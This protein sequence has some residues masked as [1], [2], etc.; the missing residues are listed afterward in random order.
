MYLSSMS[1]NMLVSALLNPSTASANG[2][3]KATSTEGLKD[4]AMNT[5]L[6]FYDDAMQE[7]MHVCYFW[8]SMCIVVK[9]KVYLV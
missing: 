8:S 5:E 7:P 6:S 4:E 2:N 9:L 3:P 1:V